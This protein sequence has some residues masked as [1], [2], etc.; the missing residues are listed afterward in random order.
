MSTGILTS[1]CSSSSQCISNTKVWMVTTMHTYHV[2]HPLIII[3]VAQAINPC[4]FP[5]FLNQ[6]I[7]PPSK[8]LPPILRQFK[9]TSNMK[10]TALLLST[11]GL[12]SA[13]SFP[14]V[15]QCAVCILF[16]RSLFTAN[17]IRTN[18]SPRPFPRSAVTRRISAVAAPMPRPCCRNWFRVLRASVARRRR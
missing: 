9:Q 15:P 4:L 10:L 12:V 16:L 13:A 11:I 1:Y 8:Y 2:N 17:G 6:P 5:D 7:Q 18:V 3:S 14:G